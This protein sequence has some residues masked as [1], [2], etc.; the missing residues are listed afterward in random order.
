MINAGF[1]CFIYCKATLDWSGDTGSASIATSVVRA[2]G[3][4]ASADDSASSSVCSSNSGNMIPA[5]NA[6]S[7]F[8][9]YFFFC[10]ILFGFFRCSLGKPLAG[11]EWIE[12][13]LGL[14]V[15]GK[16]FY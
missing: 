6:S 9:S 13:A 4:G 8:L 5:S 16:L 1:C 10:S 7:F 3:S 11:G 12:A 14:I 15:P 2:T